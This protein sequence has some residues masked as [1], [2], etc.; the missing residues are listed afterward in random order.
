MKES[1]S[2]KDAAKNKLAVAKKEC[3]IATNENLSTELQEVIFKI[4]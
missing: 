3:N 2:L 1:Q 4:L